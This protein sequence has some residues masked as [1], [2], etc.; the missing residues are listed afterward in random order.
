[1]ST[2]ETSTNNTTEESIPTALCHLHYVE[3]FSDEYCLE[4][5]ILENADVQEVIGDI[6]EVIIYKECAQVDPTDENSYRY[7]A[8]CSG[9]DWLIYTFYQPDDAECETVIFPSV[10]IDGEDG[11]FR[12]M[13]VANE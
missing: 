11:F 3:R 12:P 10:T 9:E 5:N 6:N 7:R 1:M 13:T 2:D 4:P 8:E